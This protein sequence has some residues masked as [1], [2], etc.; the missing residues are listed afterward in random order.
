MIAVSTGGLTGLGLME[1]KQKLFYLPEPELV[2]ARYER[3]LEPGGVFIISMWRATES[4]RTWRRC[5]SRLDVLHR[6]HV[7][8]GVQ[9]HHGRQRH[10]VDH[11]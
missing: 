6:H 7:T 8:T 9:H 5:A 3:F 1:G 2:L 11:A 10:D 4:L